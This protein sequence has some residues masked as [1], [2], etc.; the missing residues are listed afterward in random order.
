MLW[1]VLIFVVG[2]ALLVLG[3]WSLV[4]GSSRLALR[5]GVPSLLVGLTVVAWGTSAPELFVSLVAALRGSPGL[6]LGNVVGSNLANIGLILGLTLLVMAPRVE[7]RFWRFDV[8]ALIGAA[9]VFLLLL[10]DGRLGRGDGA[11]MMALYAAVTVLTIR[12]ALRGRAVRSVAEREEARRRAGGIPASLLLI[13]FGIALL[14]AGGHLIVEAGQRLARSFGVPELVIGLTF[15]AVGT[16]LPELATSVAAALR[17]DGGIALGNVVGSNI[18]NLLAVG[19]PVALIHP[20]DVSPGG[21]GWESGGLVVLTLAVPLAL[22]GRTPGARIV[23]GSALIVM[24]GLII[25][26]SL[27]CCR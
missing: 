4:D 8:W 21:F 14:S 11:V 15:V 13:V 3:A 17:R 19:G 5:L 6:M 1:D 12:D 16:S 18:F 27:G 9:A 2:L 10:S 20:V 7:R 24:Y 23:A 25:A 26:L 22:L